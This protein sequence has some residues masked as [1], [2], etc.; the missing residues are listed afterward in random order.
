MQASRQNPRYL[1]GITIPDSVR[2]LRASDLSPAGHDIVCLAVPAKALPAVLAAHGGRITR[3]GGVLVV[4]KGLV[5]PLGTLPSAFAAE[6][7]NARAV[8][9]IGGPAHAAEML[10]SGASIVVA[11]LDKG[12]SKQLADA[13]TA[14]KLDVS[15]TSDVSGVELA[16]CAK[17][18]AVL[19]A[20]AA[21]SQGGANVAGA[22]AG[23]VFA[24]VDALARARGCRPETFA[25]LAGAG[26]L[27]ATVVSTGSRNRRAGELLAQG[28]PASEIGRAL[29][30]SAEAVDSVPLL[31]TAAREARLDAPALDG[32]AALVEGRI[33]PDQWAATV[34]DPPKATQ[35][36]SIRAA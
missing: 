35:A 12:F 24:E 26:D 19:A 18:A 13:L 15:I 31:A 9:V 34:T 16:G 21:A 8:A 11:S 6:R 20:A 28:I 32:L 1:P 30:Q 4:S 5:P 23:K 36:R 22:A 27:V 17:N 14:A 7:C 2:V 3:R 33:E 29:G 25:G 10:E